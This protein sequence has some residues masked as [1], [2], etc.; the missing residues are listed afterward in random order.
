M[1][2]HVDSV[3]Q[4]MNTFITV[5]QAPPDKL[6]YCPSTSTSSSYTSPHHRGKPRSLG[7]QPHTSQEAV[8]GML[9]ALEPHTT[10]REQRAHLGGQPRAGGGVAG[11][12]RAG[13]PARQQERLHRARQRRHRPQRALRHLQ[14]PR[15]LGR[16]RAAVLLCVWDQESD[17]LHKVWRTPCI[18]HIHGAS[19]LNQRGCRN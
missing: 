10:N 14:L 13:P 8:V 6:L 16:L 12:R 2:G 17:L 15:Q 4:E 5:K 9:T 18:W 3:C 19:Y 1:Q 7:M 11:G